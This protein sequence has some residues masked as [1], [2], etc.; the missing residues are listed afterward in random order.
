M[1]VASDT[2]SRIKWIDTAKGYGMVLVIFSHISGSI[3]AVWNYTFHMPLFFFLSG[4]LF[5]CGATFGCFLKKKIKSLI[6]PYFAYGIPMLLFTLFLMYRNSQMTF[7]GLINLLMNFIQQKR[8]W[9]IWFITCLFIVNIIC[10][11]IVQIKSDKLKILV[12]VLLVFCGACYYKIGG[13]PLIWNLDISIMASFF[14]VM[15][16]ICRKHEI[17][18]LVMNLN[19]DIV[20]I[21]ML[22]I[23]VACWRLSIYLTGTSLNMYGEQYGVVPL[24]YTAAIAGIGI[25]VMI[26][27]KFSNKIVRYIGRNSMI[28]LAWHQTIFIPIVIKMGMALNIHINKKP[29]SIEMIFKN[30]LELIVVIAMITIC[31][32]IIEYM[33]KRIGKRV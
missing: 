24:T 3:F 23:N 30:I 2:S 11:F 16:Y 9:T 22:I 5:N 12:S 26:S 27:R 14:F 29:D 1:C 6:V 4:Y 32:I 33:K 15:G 13:G 19:K 21:A 8:M 17:I 31:N 18:N 10:Y 7:L 28:Y 25:I 20:F